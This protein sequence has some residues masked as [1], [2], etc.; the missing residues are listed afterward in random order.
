MDELQDRIQT[1]LRD[2]LTAAAANPRH[3]WHRTLNE[4]Q[5]GTLATWKAGGLAGKQWGGAALANAGLG[6]T[7]EAGEVADLIKKMLFPS[8][9]GDDDLERNKALLKEELGDLLWYVA[10]VAAE[11]GWPLSEVAGDNLEKLAKRHNVAR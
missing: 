1:A 9:P 8:K 11:M 5:I 10:I 2:G 6:I 4:F 7:G 3:Y